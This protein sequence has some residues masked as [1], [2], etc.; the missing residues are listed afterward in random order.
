MDKAQVERPQLLL[1]MA[2]AEDHVV[3]LEVIFQVKAAV[4]AVFMEAAVEVEGHKILERQ[5]QEQVV[6]FASFGLDQPVYSHQHVLAI[7]N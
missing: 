4:L 3:L 5:A 6:Q 7:L 2:E 1:D